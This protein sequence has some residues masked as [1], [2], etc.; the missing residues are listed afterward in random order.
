MDHKMNNSNENDNLTSSLFAD[1]RSFQ[2]FEFDAFAFDDFSGSNITNEVSS[3][4]V[5]EYA[6][7]ELDLDAK[8][9]SIQTVNPS[10]LH[11]LS[12][13]ALNSLPIAP[14]QLSKG[15]VSS[16]TNQ[17]QMLSK[18]PL[19]IVVNK[20]IVVPDKPFFVAVTHFCTSRDIDVVVS[21]VEH[22]LSSSLETSFD[23][24]HERCRWEC[25]YLSGASRS[26]FEF[27]TY[28][29]GDGTYIIE[30]NRLC[31]DS[32][33][34]S[35][36]FR[37]L[38]GKFS[39]DMSASPTSVTNFQFIPLP[40]TVS[41]LSSSDIADAVAPILAM[42]KSGKCESQ[43]NAAQIMCDLSLQ[44]DMMEVMCQEDCVTSLIKLV[45]VEFN[46]CNQHAVCA[47]ANL[48]TSRTCQ[49]ILLQD[50]GFMLHMLQ[51]CCNGNF[52]TAEMRRECAR[53]LA[54]V[55]SSS[56]SCAVKLVKG[57]GE[58]EVACW[59]DS[60]DDLKDERLRL[61]AERACGAMRACLA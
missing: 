47:L 25:V 12:P 18:A 45:R 31:G 58:D 44:Q 10:Q 43:V 27:N 46:Y 59:L 19:S 11:S 17:K 28:K 13:P 9:R 61:H 7:Q 55:C 33:P 53:L 30:G 40:D 5:E 14:P 15:P 38:R 20:P 48:S 52:N 23:F 2:D 8:Y 42:A 37:G 21:M 54:N 49:E 4:N 50:E 57:V 22:E 41:E 16:Q 35:T 3:I 34:F 6:F 29:N 24:Y 51:M 32:F 26:K 1:E 60:V 36:T 56:P 39:E